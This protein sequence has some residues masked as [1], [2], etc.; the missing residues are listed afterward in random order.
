MPVILTTA[1][2]VDRWLTADTANALALQ[3]P[4]PIEALRIVAKGEREDGLALT[5]ARPQ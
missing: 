5:F 3:V 4:L 1:A 2:E